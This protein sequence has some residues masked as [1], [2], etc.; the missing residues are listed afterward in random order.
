MNKEP[1]LI[2]TL[3]VFGLNRLL[4]GLNIVPPDDSMLESV[5]EFFVLVGGALIARTKVFSRDT[6]REAGLDPE[7][8][9]ARAADP[10][11]PKKLPAK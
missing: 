3:L 8:V 6:I 10:S 5:A 9:E 1:I 4:D 7:V 11:V 2:V